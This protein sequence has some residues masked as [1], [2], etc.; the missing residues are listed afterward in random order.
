M[1]N[2]LLLLIVNLYLLLAILLFALS[3]NDLA[4][5]IRN[6]TRCAKHHRKIKFIVAFPLMLSCLAVLAIGIFAIG[7]SHGSRPEEYQVWLFILGCL[8]PFILLIIWSVGSLFVSYI[9]IATTTALFIYLSFFNPAIYVQYW[10]DSNIHWAQMWMA[11]Q[12]STGHGGV[13]KSDSRARNWYEKAAVNGNK[14]A[15][16]KMAGL[17]RRSTKA[18]KW[19]LLAA[20]QGHVDAMVQMARVASSDEERQRWLN[21]AVSHHHPEAVFMLAKKVMTNDL[22]TARQLLL[23]A[24]E[25]GSR[26]AIVFLITQYQQGGVLF[27]RNHASANQWRSVLEKTPRSIT[28]PAHLTLATIDLTVKQVQTKGIK[29]SSEEPVMLYKR[30]QLF[31]H[32]PAKD[33]VLHDRALD[34][35]TRAANKGHDESAIELAKLA[36]Q[37]S[38]SAQPNAEALKWYEMAAGNNNLS[39]LTEL[40]LYYKQQK[41]ANVTDLEHSL[42][43]N[44]KLL[45]ALQAS[46]TKQRMKQQHWTAE[47]RDTEKRLSQLKRLGGSWQTAIKQAG[48]N[49]QKEY[50]L[51]KE[52]ID[53]GQYVSGMQHMK[54]AA[55]R[56]DPEARL[57]L[58]SRTL[59][60]PR[61]FTQEIDAISELQAL[62][63]LGL[64]TASIKLGTIYQSGTGI[65]PRNYYLARQLFRK[66]QAD[67]LLS[68]K[69]LR[70]L[71]RTPDFT[72]SLKLKPIDDNN[73]IIETWYQQE[74]HQVQD[75]I[76]LQKQYEALQ[77]HFRDTGILKRHA[78]AN[79]TISQYQLAQ[80]L[81][82]HNLAEA[83]HW[84]QR[85]A[86]NGDS[87]AQYELA[88]RMIRGKRNT[89]KIQRDLKNLAATAANNGHIGAMVFLAFQLK[90]GYGGFENNTDLAK[91]YYLEALQSTDSDILYH[92]RI[93]GRTISIKRSNIQKALAAIK[94]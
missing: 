45:S 78:A 84:L 71:D 13:V 80:S 8:A 66:A 5:Q 18:R 64:L 17:E 42:E 16:Y 49:P 29:I 47:Y 14:D 7:M 86:S 38:E 70:L 50:L 67:P 53:N 33:Q 60:G 19:Y 27:E 41:N 83:I 75:T 28:E 68:E 54:S 73:E 23:D 93:A 15:Q 12:Y 20:E 31:L 24:A 94:Q 36:M 37:E 65:V 3:A 79:D 51:A 56:E 77:D 48:E 21:L 32:H 69:A 11:R 63:R 39:A 25:N 2:L 55:Q 40:T 43:Y 91:D 6:G 26:T 1:D 10:A 85:A 35:L 59:R 82:S 52:L 87:N 81:Q 92:G 76:L 9:W 58:A 89:P 4:C 46:N 22:P 62:D 90:K 61:S 34:Y 88:V 74:K 72:D 44:D 57:Y 30:A